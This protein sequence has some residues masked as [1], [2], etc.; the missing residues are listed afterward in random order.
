MLIIVL[1]TK[2][3][4][5]KN[6]IKYY[7]FDKHNKLKLIYNTFQFRSKMEDWQENHI[8]QNLPKLIRLTTFNTLVKAELIAQSV[9]DKAEIDKLVCKHTSF[10]K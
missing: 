7:K 4:Y 5:H 6:L 2:K 9:L 3:V 10:K 8:K 1:S